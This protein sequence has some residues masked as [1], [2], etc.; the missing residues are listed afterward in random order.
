M[1]GI[2]LALN[3][4]GINALTTG[5]MRSR[6]CGVQA[7]HRLQLE[8][9]AKPQRLVVEAEVCERCQAAADGDGG[10]R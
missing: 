5:A 3:Q 9:L 1:N 6:A 4:H 10:A 7:A 2:W 8:A